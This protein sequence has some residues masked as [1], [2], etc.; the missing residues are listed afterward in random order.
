M[1]NSIENQNSLKFKTFMKTKD[2]NN[3]IEI[4]KSGIIMN[5]M[6]LFY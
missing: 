6:F 1:K 5:K 2:I 4:H 3:V